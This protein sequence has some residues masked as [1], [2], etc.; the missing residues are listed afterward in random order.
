MQKLEATLTHILSQLV[1]RWIPLPKT[2]SVWSELHPFDLSF[3]DW[4]D[5]IDQ[6]RDRWRRTSMEP[7]P[8]L[9]YLEQHFQAYQSVLVREII[10]HLA[11]LRNLRA[12][13]LTYYCQEYPDDLRQ[14]PDPP[15]ALSL[16]GSTSLLTQPKLAIIGARRASQRALI[17]ARKLGKILSQE[18]GVIVSG[19][20]IGCDRSAHQGCLDS[21]I[22]PVP[23]IAVMA[24]GLQQLYPRYN[25]SLFMEMKHRQGLF[26][27]ERLC[28][29]RPRPYDFPVRNRIIAGLSQ[30]II[31]MEAAAKSGALVTANLGLHFGRDVVILEP[32]QDDIRAEGSRMLE[33]DGAPSFRSAADYWNLNWMQD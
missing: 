24:G 26:I 32:D 6:Q 7:S 9:R 18:G 21:G 22:T 16:L 1:Y 8:W 23:T 11:K 19:G 5:F 3:A 25:H 14:I 12:S 28:E 13:Y 20:A 30:R 10:H 29:A 15:A 2:C 17:E 31:V 33:Q 27:S 4:Q